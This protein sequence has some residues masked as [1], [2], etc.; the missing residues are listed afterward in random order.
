MTKIAIASDCKCDICGKENKELLKITDEG[1]FFDTDIY[2]CQS[3]VSKWFK[4]FQKG[5]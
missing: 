5:K 3:C 2:V 1:L 4:S